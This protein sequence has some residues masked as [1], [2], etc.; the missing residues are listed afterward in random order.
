LTTAQPR[1]K[2]DSKRWWKNRRR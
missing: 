2:N 1:T